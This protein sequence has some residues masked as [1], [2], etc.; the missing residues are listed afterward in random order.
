MPPVKHILLH[1][2]DIPRYLLPSGALGRSHNVHVLHVRAVWDAGG[3][4]PE[5][6]ESAVKVNDGDGH[7]ARCGDERRDE[8]VDEVKAGAEAGEGERGEVSGAVV[9]GDEVVEGG[10][11]ED[12]TVGRGVVV[13]GG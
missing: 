3:E 1:S 10:G 8:V 9:A 11:G 2:L 12:A 7:G 6:V 4:Q 5:D 13:G